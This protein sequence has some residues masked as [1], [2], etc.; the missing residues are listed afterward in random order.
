MDFSRERGERSI[1]DD[2]LDLP[3]QPLVTKMDNHVRIG[4]SEMTTLFLHV[5]SCVLGH[6]PMSASTSGPSHGESA[7]ET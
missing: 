2:V 1:D 7:N 6:L 4:I 3:F 5:S